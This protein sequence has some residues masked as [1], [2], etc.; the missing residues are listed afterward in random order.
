MTDITK[1]TADIIIFILSQRLAFYAMYGKYRTVRNYAQAE[2]LPHIAIFF[3][4]SHPSAC[5]EFVFLLTYANTLN[6]HQPGL[7]R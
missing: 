7:I 6:K 5:T 3:S 1:K 4:C 2:I